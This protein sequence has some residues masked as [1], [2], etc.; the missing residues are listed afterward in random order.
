[1]HVLVGRASLP[2]FYRS[3]PHRLY[4][5]WAKLFRWQM[6]K[7]NLGVAHHCPQRVKFVRGLA[8][9]DVVGLG[10]LPVS[11][12]HLDHKDDVLNL[13][14]VLCDFARSREFSQESCVLCF[15]GGLA[16]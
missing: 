7:Q 15:A 14:E 9:F 10:E 1:M 6:G 8:I 12:Q 2:T 4:R 11:G 3:L 13:R 16:R 5:Q